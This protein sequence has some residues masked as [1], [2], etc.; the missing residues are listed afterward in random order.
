MLAEILVVGWLVELQGAVDAG[1]QVLKQ[2]LFPLRRSVYVHGL[3][4]CSVGC[5]ILA[6]L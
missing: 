1:E 3:A 6:V 2:L 5:Y 4:H